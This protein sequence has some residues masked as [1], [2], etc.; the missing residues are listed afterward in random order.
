MGA[1][2]LAAARLGH[3]RRRPREF[4]WA[5]RTQLATQAARWIS[6]ATLR[7]VIL[8]RLRRCALSR[9]V[10]VSCASA[11]A[12]YLLTAI[13]L[14]GAALGVPQRYVQIDRRAVLQDAPLALLG[15]TV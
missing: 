14:V 5:R 2:A 11:R 1:T 8:V 10:A 15:S 6:W 3:R 9:V 12:R 4:G 7:S 13:P